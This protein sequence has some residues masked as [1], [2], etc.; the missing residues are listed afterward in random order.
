MKAVNI[1][2]FLRYSAAGELS[3]VQIQLHRHFPLLLK[4]F[5]KTDKLN[6][7]NIATFKTAFA[8]MAAEC[9]ELELTASLATIRQLQ[10]IL[11]KPGPSYSMLHPLVLE[12]QER[13]IDEAEAKIFL[14]LSIKEANLY[15][16]PR[17]GWK[18]IIDRFPHTV[19]DIEEASKCFALSRYG[20]AVFHSIQVVEVGVIE[21]EKLITVTDPLPGWTAT[22]NRLQTIIKKGHEA[23][24]PFERQNFAF[25]EQIH[26]TIEG[27][28]NAWRNKNQPR[29][30]QTH[31]ADHRL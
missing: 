18:Q 31:T 1:A 22:T 15:K 29:A 5:G 10:N 17:E 24:T 12:L 30:W 2:N 26:G 20:A 16:N 11:L 21:F 8:H 27:L 13:L 9:T 19:R 3:A 7:D 14:S 28:K 4:L 6:H 23:R 25:I